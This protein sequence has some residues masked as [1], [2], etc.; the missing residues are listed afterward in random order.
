MKTQP[1]R[2]KF[3][4]SSCLTAGG[5][6]VIACGGLGFAATIKPPLE[7]P[8]TSYGDSTMNNRILVTY[9]TQAGSTAEVAAQVAKTLTDRNPNV[10]LKPVDKVTD[11][12]PY[13]TVILGSAIMAGSVLP[14]AK[15]FIEKNQ[16]ALQ[17]KTLHV[18]IVCMTLKDD[19]A[20][21]RAAVSA[22]LEPVRA[23]VKP[24]SEGL[25]T[26]RYDPKKLSLVLRLVMSMMKTP[27]GDFRNW[28]E[29]KGWAENV[30]L[31]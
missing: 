22:Y 1:S 15:K 18:F 24:A 29:I 9:A 3:L 30:S 2:R 16:A 6:G 31:N 28:E 23:L 25:F 4:K 20:E 13:S 5:I 10:D 27:Q 17:A 8:S 7:T 19:T 11:L 26:G 14:A 21:N 12:T